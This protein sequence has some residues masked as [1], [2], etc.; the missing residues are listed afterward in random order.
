MNEPSIPGREMRKGINF[1]AIALPSA[2]GSV[3]IEE[4]YGHKSRKMK[5][6]MNFPSV[7]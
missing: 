1:D 3:S 6:T 7:S 4:G 2:R 5:W